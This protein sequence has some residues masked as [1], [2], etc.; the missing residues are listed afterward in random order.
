[1]EAP[2]IARRRESRG[3]HRRPLLNP[4]GLLLLVGV[5]LLFWTWGRLPDL[6]VDYGREVYVPWRLSLGDRLYA[7]LAY[8]N[9]PLSPYLNSLVF[10]LFSPGI[11][12]LSLTNAGLL[13]VTVF[14]LFQLLRAASDES[15]ATLACLLFL[16]V[17]AFQVFQPGPFNY[18]APYSH[19]MTHGML[20]SLLGLWAVE[21]YRRV[22]GYRWVFVGGI[23]LGLAF[24]TKPEIALAAM[25][26]P[27][28]FGIS[29]GERGA[30]MPK[31]LRHGLVCL[32]SALAVVG[33]GYVLLVP[34]LSPEL[35]LRGILAPWLMAADREVTSLPF[36]Q[37]GLGI[38]D[39]GENIRSAA[40]W[41]G[42]YAVLLG[43]PL[44]L[45]RLVGEPKGPISRAGWKTS[46]FF[47]SVILS[48]LLWGLGGLERAAR[49][50][51]F[52]VLAFLV[53]EGAG[54]NLLGELAGKGRRRTL[55]LV[56]LAFSLVLL[57]KMFFSARVVGYGFVLAMPAT[58]MATVALLS[59]IPS[60]LRE[61]GRW[62]DL[63][64]SWASGFVV[65]FAAAHLLVAH[66]KL[67][68]K[69]FP[70]A[71][72]SDVIMTDPAQGLV[73]EK[74]LV[75][76]G[77][78]LGVGGGLAVIPEGAMVNYLLNARN[79]TPYFNFMPPEVVHFGEEQIVEA[80]TQTPP[81]V[82]L[83]V[84]KDVGFY[85]VGQFGEGYGRT[86]AAWIDGNYELLERLGDRPFSRGN[87]FGID[88]MVLRD[89]L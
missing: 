88:V 42:A 75:V 12:V 64:R 21:E 83:L 20:M 28:G 46:L 76:A 5:G 66:G 77:R 49:P 29:A 14:L 6:L 56:L 51:P 72:G 55:R 43:L 26:I 87:A 62:G 53:F 13:A 45:E 69:S 74:A 32:V 17:F 65:A 4:G 60:R 39:L 25:V 78:L 70:V 18:I 59:W 63:F 73:V 31:I 35:A 61:K 36:Y 79:P 68:E 16:A 85:G 84:H 15:S 80:F 50:L 47:I 89:G 8:F 71:V 41:G 9:G 33:V 38:D 44:A 82:L 54:T 40:A 22:G 57:L 30:T 24:L 52:L 58:M 48:F 86:L 19:E 67:Q 2:M 34:I 3:A 11:L 37:T 1:M 23:P 7:D 81:E 27:V 10:K